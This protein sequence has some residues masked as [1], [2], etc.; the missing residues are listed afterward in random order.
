MFD[1]LSFENISENI[2]EEVDEEIENTLIQRIMA[3]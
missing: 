1:D 3:K 2:E